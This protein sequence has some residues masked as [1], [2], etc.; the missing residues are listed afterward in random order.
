MLLCHSEGSGR[1]SERSMMGCVEKVVCRIHGHVLFLVL[2]LL[3]MNGTD[4]ISMAD[5]GRL[6]NVAL[7]VMLPSPSS[8][9]Q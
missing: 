5:A 4:F 3:V 6:A 2:A 7:C 9:V 8:A 1:S